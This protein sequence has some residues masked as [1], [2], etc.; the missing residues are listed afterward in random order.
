[1]DA[2]T[3]EKADQLIQAVEAQKETDIQAAVAAAVAPK[4]AE[5]A[6]LQATISQKDAEAGQQV[7]EGQNQIL[8]LI[9]S[10]LIRNQ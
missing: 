10:R 3:Q 1:M 6:Q 2:E 7:K 5:I 8:L 4:D 9:K